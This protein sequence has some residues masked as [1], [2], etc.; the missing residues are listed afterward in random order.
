MRK[1]KKTCK[2]AKGL[3]ARVHREEFLDQLKNPKKYVKKTS[4]QTASEI[5]AKIRQRAGATPPQGTMPSSPYNAGHGGPM[6]R[7][8]KKLGLPT[9]LK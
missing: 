6:D 1:L 5:L 9:S 4:D 7:L 8:R 2:K 3:K